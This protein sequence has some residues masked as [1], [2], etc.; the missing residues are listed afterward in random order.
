MKDHYVFVSSSDQ[1]YIEI[2]YITRD[3]MLCFYDGEFTRIPF[4]PPSEEYCLEQFVEF[5][6]FSKSWVEA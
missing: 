1:E 3:S 5:H 4:V 2:R 6:R